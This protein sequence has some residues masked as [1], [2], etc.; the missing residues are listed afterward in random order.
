MKNFLLFRN[1]NVNKKTNLIYSENKRDIQEY[2]CQ[3]AK[4]PP[5]PVLK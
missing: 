1:V 3:S 4:K 5:M 2:L